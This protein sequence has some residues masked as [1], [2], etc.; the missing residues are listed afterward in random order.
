MVQVEPLCEMS[1]MFVFV[2]KVMMRAMVPSVV[3]IG[4]AREEVGYIIV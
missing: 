1:I 3:W 4:K 2:Q